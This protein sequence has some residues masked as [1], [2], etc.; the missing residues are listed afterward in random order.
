M[1]PVVSVL[2]TV[3]SIGGLSAQATTVTRGQL[4]TIYPQ[5]YTKALKNPL[6]G[7]RLHVCSKRKIA[8]YPYVTLLRD[9]VE[10][11]DL[12]T[13]STDNLVRNIEAYK[14][15]NWEKYRGLGVKII[16]RVYLDWDKTIG[17]EFWPEDMTSGDYSSAEFKK[18]VVR[19]IHA[20]GECWDNDPIVAWVQ[21]G[22]I[23]YWGEHHHPSPD[24]EMQ[25]IMGDAFSKAFSNKHILI[26]HPGEFNGYDFG[27]YWD[28]WAH[29]RQTT[30]LMH[31][32][33]IEKLNTDTDRW[34]TRPIAGEVAYDWGSF[35]IQPGDNPDDTLS[36]PIHREFLIDTIRNLHCS[37]LGWIADYDP[38]D[39]TSANGAEMVQRAFGYRYVLETFSYVP[40]VATSGELSVSFQIKNT[41][42][43]PFLYDWPV[44]INLLETKTKKIVFSQ[45]IDTVDIRNWLPGDDW[46]ED[47]N[48]YL[49]PAISNT[50]N[51]SV[52]LP[53]H[54]KLSAGK[55]IVSL[56]IIEPTSE[57]NAIRLAIKNDF[58]E[59]HHHLGYLQYGSP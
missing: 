16:P 34:K 18:R 26:R 13:R 55:Y 5:E 46:D 32:A 15:K 24:L 38:L 56:S 10:W 58:Y 20:L 2:V 57:A 43:A 8:K 52:P 9:Y 1:L 27:I 49:I 12:E 4:I 35:T 39:L 23:G 19:M 30:Q 40:I 31:G 41:G 29:N 59:G 53:K 48:E 3:F 21:M 17:N 28:S 50:V 54:D 33:G 44:C 42:S 11:N 47:K 45:E 25:K 6:K 51:M 22:I 36:D 14:L 7:F 37:A